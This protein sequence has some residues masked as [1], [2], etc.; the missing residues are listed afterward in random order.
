MVWKMKCRSNFRVSDS[1]ANDN[2]GLTEN[3][4]TQWSCIIS[5]NLR[6]LFLKFLFG[7]FID[8]AWSKMHVIRFSNKAGLLLKVCMIPFIQYSGKD[9]NYRDSRSVVTKSFWKGSGLNRWN[10]RDSSQS[11]EAFP[12]IL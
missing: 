8:L 12:M 6:F 4:S 5:G 11:N 1:T 10:K 9:K 2:T 7:L 3:V